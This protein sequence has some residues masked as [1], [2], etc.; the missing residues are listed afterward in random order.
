MERHEIL[1]QAL[2]RLD[3]HVHTVVLDQATAIF[4]LEDVRWMRLLQRDIDEL[5]RNE[6]FTGLEL[7][8]R[9]P[10]EAELVVLEQSPIDG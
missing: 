9:G 4:Q 6:P 5:R 1:Q 8:I 10:N 2:D 7:R 3:F